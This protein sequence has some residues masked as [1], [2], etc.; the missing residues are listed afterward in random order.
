M[1]IL[2][3]AP[4][5][6]WPLTVQSYLKNSTL[7]DEGIFSFLNRFTYSSSEVACFE[8]T[9]SFEWFSTG[10]FSVALGFYIDNVTCIMLFVVSLISFLVA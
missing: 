2:S 10:D 5:F 3:P 8:F 4:M 1:E 9:K 6:Y 7:Y